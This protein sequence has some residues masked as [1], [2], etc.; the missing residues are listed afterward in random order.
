M[1][2]GYE[3]QNYDGSRLLE[4]RPFHM[5]RNGSGKETVSWHREFLWLQMLN[6]GRRT[7]AMAVSDAHTV[8][9][10][11]V[12]GWRMYMPSASDEPS[13][14]DWRENVRAAKAGKSYL[15]TGP[16]LQVVTPTGEGPGETILAQGKSIT[17]RVR[18]QCS[19][20][21]DIDRVQVLVNGRAAASLN[22]TR[23]THPSFFGN[24]VLKFDQELTVPLTRDSHVIVVACGENFT[25]KTGYG[26]SPQASIQPF[27]YHNPVWVDV[28]GGGVSVV[29]DM[30]DFSGTGKPLGVEEAKAFLEG[31]K[32]K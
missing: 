3:T 20:W 1:I 29:D 2:D 5:A 23:T 6:Q 24:G 8:F 22:F 7:N 14:I 21:I 10:N 26:S 11:G 19:D 31:G 15:T 32:V 25:L 18:V 12:G 9:G 17:L 4:S 13:E 16:F 27:A 28:D 30:L